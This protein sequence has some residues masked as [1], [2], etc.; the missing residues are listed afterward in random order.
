ML[1]TLVVITVPSSKRIAYGPS[2]PWASMEMGLDENRIEFLGSSSARL[3]NNALRC[4]VMGPSLLQ[5]RQ[6]IRSLHIHFGHF[7]K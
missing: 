6:S 5:I 1:D 7:E 2:W 3:S 4:T